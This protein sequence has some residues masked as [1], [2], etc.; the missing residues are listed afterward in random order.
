M[1]KERILSAI[2]M[3]ILAVV[4]L[5]W[6]SPLAFTIGLSAIVVLG[7]WEWA[8]FAGFKRPI[9]RAIVAFVVTCLLIFPI[10]AGTSY[11][12]ATRFLTDETTPLLFIGG[13][14]WLVA[15]AL[16]VSYPKSADV[17]AKSVV[18]KFIFGFCTLIPFLI[19]TL[20]LRF[21]QYNL[22]QY[23]GTYLL[24]YVF[25]L[26]W[27]ADS[28]AYFSG[29]A[30]GKH[31]LAPKVS[32]SKSWEGAIGGVITS[33]VIATI[34]LSVVPANVFGRE[35]NTSAFV[36]LSVITVAISI[37]GDLSESMFKRQVGIKDSSNLI[38][39]HGG[40]LDR[41]DSLTAAVPIFAIGFFFFL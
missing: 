17:W 29:R 24:L 4:A 3:I 8:Q 6:L 15:S 21:Y 22:D 1:L 23:Q 33:A 27:G 11:I 16:V 12:Q 20:A 5:F 19:G 41:I 2:V 28:G 37:L 18:A 39:G 34:F 35:L 26:V 10:M 38:P 25:L 30:F 32:P 7:M 31:K 14:W 9:A 13:F 36:V 40:I